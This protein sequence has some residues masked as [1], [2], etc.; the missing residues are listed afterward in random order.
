MSDTRIE[1]EEMEEVILY[2]MR[3]GEEYDEW[4]S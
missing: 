3:R 4:S 1:D 2:P